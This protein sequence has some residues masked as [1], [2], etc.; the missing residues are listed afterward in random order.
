MMSKVI[1]DSEH[2]DM[3]FSGNAW[4]DTELESDATIDLEKHR[5]IKERVREASKVHVNADDNDVWDALMENHFS[6]DN[7]SP[8]NHS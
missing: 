4:L 1:G 6:E 2:R 7:F 3:L 8:T 5:D